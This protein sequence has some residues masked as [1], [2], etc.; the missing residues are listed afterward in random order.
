MS[1]R[2][3]DRRSCGV[4]EGIRPAGQVLRSSNV[5]WCGRL[6]DFEVL[7]IVSGH[8]VILGCWG[9]LLKERQ[10]VDESLQCNS[11]LWRGDAQP[12]VKN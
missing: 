1:G 11:N 10:I 2:Y 8:G 7:V 9:G 3:G 12:S 5:I 4:A 6:V